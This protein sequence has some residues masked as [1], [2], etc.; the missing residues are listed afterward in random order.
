MFPGESMPRHKKTL[1][2]S[3]SS[4]R[5]NDDANQRRPNERGDLSG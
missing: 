4:R 5:S 3:E 2:A 1:D